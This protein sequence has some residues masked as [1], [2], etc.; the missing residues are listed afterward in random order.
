VTFLL[1]LGAPIIHIGVLDYMTIF[2]M[3]SLMLVFVPFQAVAL[4]SG[5]VIHRIMYPEEEKD[6]IKKPDA[7]VSAKNVTANHSATPHKAMQSG[8]VLPSGMSFWH[9]S[10]RRHRIGATW[11]M[12]TIVVNP[13]MNWMVFMDDF[14]SVL[15]MTFEIVPLTGVEVTE[16]SSVDAEKKAFRCLVKTGVGNFS[17]ESEWP[18]LMAKWKTGV[19]RKV[20]APVA[21]AKGG[22]AGLTSVNIVRS[23][24]LN[25]DDRV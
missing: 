24:G 7:N 6:L 25:S 19:C 10:V 16:E 3:L 21:S 11:E 18:E 23:N 14:E 2:V 15:P 9:F 13:E 12:M 1:C 8:E 20:Q 17:F 22:E 4:I 5:P